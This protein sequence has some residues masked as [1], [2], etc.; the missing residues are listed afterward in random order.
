MKAQ[1]LEEMD[2]QVETVNSSD[3][4][5]FA[6]NEDL[7]TEGVLMEPRITQS[8]RDR[9]N[10]LADV[11]EKAV[12]QRSASKTAAMK[13]D[14][15]AATTKEKIHSAED[16]KSP[17]KPELKEM[18]KCDSGSSP[19]ADAAEA[20][21][22]KRKKDPPACRA[23]VTPE[24]KAQ[25][26]TSSTVWCD[27]CKKEWRLDDLVRYYKC[28]DTKCNAEMV[29]YFRDDLSHEKAEA[30]TD[31]LDSKKKMCFNHTGKRFAITLRDIR[32]RNRIDASIVEQLLHM[33][34]KAIEG[35]LLLPEQYKLN[36]DRHAGIQD[37]LHNCEVALAMEDRRMFRSSFYSLM[38]FVNAGYSHVQPLRKR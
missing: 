37:S 25:K 10:G 32:K 27:D 12:E 36:V 19:D 24:K 22:K 28:G 20:A 14:A 3:S 26:K 11:G 35:G 21:N 1:S 6:N 2:V 31:A 16:D 18:F 30:T 8:D 29:D 13:D 7:P 9:H 23:V 33:K 15:T 5:G 34:K 38:H 4:T 17:L